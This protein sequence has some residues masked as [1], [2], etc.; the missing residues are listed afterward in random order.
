MAGRGHKVDIVVGVKDQASRAL[1]GIQNSVSGMSRH[2]NTIGTHM[3]AF[4][5]NLD[6]TIS[7]MDRLANSMYKFNMYTSA[8]QRGIGTIG[9]IGVGVGGGV[10]YQG[11][12]KALDFDYKSRI[13]QSRMETTDGVRREINDYI[14]GTLNNSVSFT[15]SQLA[16][17]GIVL[18]AA[19]VS[20]TSDMKS[21]M[22]TTSYFSE[23]VDAVPEQAA[24]MVISAAKG[25]GISM[26]NS[27]TITD[28]LTV[29]LNKSLLH[30]EEMP[31]AIGELAGRA[32]MF[33][34]SLDSSLVALMTMRDQGMSAAQGSQDF[35]HA[36][37]Q[38]SRIGNDKVLFKRTQ[39]Y[40]DELGITNAIFDKDTRQLKEFPELISDI[41]QAMIKQNFVNPKYNVTND[42]EY[43]KFISD[44]GG[45]APSDFWD[46]EKAMPMITRVFG[47][48]GQAPILMGL[49]SKYEEIDKATG[50]K[51]GEIFYGSEALKKMYQEVKNSDGSVDNVHG[52]IAQ[53][54]TFNL[55]VLQ[56]AWEA[57][58]IKLLDGIIPLIST[59][60]SLLTDFI[61]GKSSNKKENGFDTFRGAISE[62]SENF[63]KSGNT[64]TAEVVDTVGNFAVDSAQIST[65]MPKMFK[66]I[67]KSFNENILKADWGSSIIEFPWKIIENGIAFVTDLVKA[68]ESFNEAV[69]KLPERLQD[70]AKLIETLTKGGLVLLVS[71][72]IVKVVELTLRT[73]ATA[74]EGIKLGANFTKAI[75]KILLG[76]VDDVT[77]GKGGS[78]I[79]KALG[80]NATINA[81]I[82]NV[83]GKAINGGTG[84]DIPDGG[85][86]KSKKGGK[87]TTP[88]GNKGGKGL[89]N[90]PVTKNVLKSPYTW[91]ALA[92]ASIIGGSAWGWSKWDGSYGGTEAKAIR[93]VPA[94]EKSNEE[95]IR[96]IQNS[97]KFT[98]ENVEGVTNYIKSEFTP[99]AREAKQAAKNAEIKVGKLK[100]MFESQQLGKES[101]MPDIT[102]EIR[103]QLGNLTTSTVSA[104]N[105]GFSNVSNGTSTAVLNGMNVI[106]TQTGAAVSSSMNNFTTPALSII[107]SGIGNIESKTSGIT[108]SII[109]GFNTANSRLQNIR[110]NNNVSVNVQPPRVNI[111]GNIKQYLSVDAGQSST[112]QTKSDR[113]MSMMNARRL[114]WN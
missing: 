1:R 35:L 26:D 96:E 2:F 99:E 29:A 71:G 92:G 87:T 11:T 30:V 33:G 43:R 56:G 85:A 102:P 51:T 106:G 49:Q 52:I 8:L 75:K 20:N 69:A 97:N 100:E 63:R 72:A 38:A 16:D 36:L 25:F 103:S 107:G 83:Y 37:R 113:R 41:E 31:H 47:A 18:G 57:A 22:K 78:I 21:M 23:A 19:G 14:L 110:L 44:N 53:S 27:G 28:K 98:K 46:S 88:N 59:G 77:P 17:M 74:L 58:Q 40:F 39:S 114:G 32:N 84:A 4:N 86:G 112:F 104:V 45:V 105:Q 7:K 76:S 15:P 61:S 5:R 68:N 9:A 73:A 111:S 67:G 13:M 66:Q 24:E 95:V 101:P 55:E 10:A 108:P 109:S 65:V 90:N 91:G 93:G 42:K 12:Q 79:E 70:P 48:A 62:T 64:T 80:K 89:L 34:Q 54:G 82:V 81:N 50:E 60:S 94:Q 6:T 3:G